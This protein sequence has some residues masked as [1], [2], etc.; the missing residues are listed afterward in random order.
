MKKQNRLEAVKPV[1]AETSP[2]QPEVFTPK[3]EDQ[4]VLLALSA[5]CAELQNSFQLASAQLTSKMFQTMAT[6]KLTPGEWL[7]HAEQCVFSKAPKAEEQKP[8]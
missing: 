3:P 1:T 6:E 7:F 4:Q 2:S 5:R 8:E